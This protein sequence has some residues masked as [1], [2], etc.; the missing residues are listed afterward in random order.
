MKRIFILVLLSAFSA[1]LLSQANPVKFK[2]LTVQEGLSRSWVKCI[3]QDSVGYLWV[4][5]A[6]GLNRYDGIS[7]KTYYCEFVLP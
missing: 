5:T 7:F 1:I 2:H 4:G 3:F 6:D